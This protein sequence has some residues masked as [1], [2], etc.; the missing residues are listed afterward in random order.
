[1]RSLC[2]GV[3][4]LLLGSSATPLSAQNG[5]TELS[6][7]DDHSYYN[8][9]WG[10]TAPDG[11]EYA[12]IG[13]FDGTAFYNVVNPA[14]PYQVGFINGPA[15]IWRDMKTYDTYCYIVTEG[16]GGVQ[17]VDLTNP[18]SPN[19][20]TTFGTGLWSHAHNIAI[21][22]GAG[23]AYVVGADPSPGVAVL[24]LASPT[25]PVFLTN[26]DTH[27]VHDAE[28]KNGLAHFAELHDGRY[29]IL[30]VSSLPTITSLD[31]VVTPDGVTHN[32]SPN[33]TDT[34]AATTDESNSGGIAIYD[35]SDPNDIQLLSTWK[36]S[37]ATVHNVLIAGDRA[38][39][40]WYS[41]GFACLDISDPANPQQIAAFDSSGAS[42]FGFDGTWGVYPHAASGLVYLSDQDNGLY[43][44]R[45]DAPDIDLSGPASVTP[46][47]S[48]SFDI[49]GAASSNNCYLLVSGSN[50]GIGLGGTTFEIGAGWSLFTSGTTD[51]NG[52]I[53][54]PFTVPAG[55]SGRS[56]FFEAATANGPVLTSNL[57]RVEVQ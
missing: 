26:Y 31:S 44:V 53:S 50:A 46:G 16:G 49:T 2:L 42:G 47:S 54:F 6:R 5:A 43:V 10:Y 8:D 30:D 19:L 28:V 11:R 24:D 21:D 14:A 52:D 55:T 45:I 34:I 35:I 20:V 39:V 33:P 18:E 41:F 32:V 9:I 40:S 15:S 23:I 4:G 56:A 57:F 13:T 12:I 29:R 36:N 22:T 38:Y 48:H 27:E 7:T 51:A 3:V 37:D 17:I 25:A 1:M